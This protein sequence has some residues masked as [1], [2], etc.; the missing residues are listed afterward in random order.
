MNRG[1]ARAQGGSGSDF[2]SELYRT[3]GLLKPETL[4]RQRARCPRYFRA[5][6]PQAPL[7]RVN[8]D[9]GGGVPF[10]ALRA[11]VAAEIG[12]QPLVTLA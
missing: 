12:E 10:F 8:A 1:L 3:I 9:E 11:Q 7:E 2:R 5:T 6:Q 4:P